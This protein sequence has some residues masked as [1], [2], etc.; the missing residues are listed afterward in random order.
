MHLILTYARDAMQKLNGARKLFLCL[1]LAG[2]LGPILLV[3]HFISGSDWSNLAIAAVGAYCGCN[4][5]S[6][7]I[8]AKNPDKEQ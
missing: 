2:F 7:Y 3:L 6:E 1:L 8:S 4:V 5:L